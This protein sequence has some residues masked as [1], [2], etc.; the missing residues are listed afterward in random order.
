MTDALISKLLELKN[1]MNTKRIHFNMPENNVLI[2]KS[3]LVGFIEGDGSFSLE[4][5]TFEPIFS[6][7]LSETQLPLLVK[8]KEFLVNNL[9]FDSYSMHKIKNTPILSITTEKARDIGKS[10][11][12]A[13]FMIKNTHVLNNYLIPFL[14]EEEFMTKKVKIF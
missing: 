13:V 6:I 5:A 1:N 8:I 3:W 14:S 12:L 2:T 11:P 4:R 9:G 7:K 10:I